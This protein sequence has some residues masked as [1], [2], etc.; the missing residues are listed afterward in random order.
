MSAY[1]SFTTADAVLLVFAVVTYGGW[2][3]AWAV[4]RTVRS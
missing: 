4:R 1:F 2:A 3:V